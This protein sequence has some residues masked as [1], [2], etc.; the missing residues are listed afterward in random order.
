[1]NSAS[2]L[3]QSLDAARDQGASDE[4]LV[5]LLRGREWPE[6]TFTACSQ[7]I[8]RAA[9]VST[10]PVTNAPAPP[11]TPSCIYSA[12]QRWL[13]GLSASAQSSSPS[14]SAGSPIRSFPRIT[15]AA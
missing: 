1:M 8:L 13:R 6:E 9:P 5:A 2:D 12:F 11:N 10:F 7:T 15:T 14:S 3:K 4:T